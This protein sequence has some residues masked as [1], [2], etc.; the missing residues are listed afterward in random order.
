MQLRKF[1]FYHFHKNVSDIDIINIWL[2]L[3]KDSEQMIDHIRVKIP[4]A[5]IS[6]EKALEDI[7]TPGFITP[8]STQSTF[9]KIILYAQSD[10]LA[11]SAYKVG[12]SLNEHQLLYLIPKK[13]K[14]KAEVFFNSRKVPH[15][16]YSYSLLRSFRPDVFVMLNDWSKEAQ[17]IIAHCHLL[18]IPVICLQESVIDFGDKY[19]RM[20][21]ADE[22]FVQGSQTV[23][24]LPR[25]SYYITGNPRYENISKRKNE[26]SYVLINCNFTYGIFEDKR[27]AWLDD[28]HDILVTENL[29]YVISQH[30]RDTGNLSKYN[31]TILSSS[32]SIVD[33]LNNTKFLIT[34]FS[35]LIH[36]ALVMG[37]P[38]IYY[39]PH[40]EKMLYDFEFDGKIVQ[41]ARSR[42]ELAN[43]VKTVKDLIVDENYLNQYL[44]KHCICKTSPPSVNIA[45]ILTST[46]FDP[47]KLTA[48]DVV[49]LGLYHP[50]VK[51]I[52]S[53]IR[54]FFT[55]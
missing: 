43:C 55:K 25:S 2:P 21:W 9:R 20:Q 8:I 42:E 14:E 31:K 24:D 44:T 50:M 10:T 53:K 40:G 37:I 17:R 34:R 16:K 51:N 36:E 12:E 1:Y 54:R 49:K 47:V 29:E 52:L 28:I 38:V 32:A 19:K 7:F 39:N 45:F 48:T 11:N 13:S 23:I 15:Q 26:G 41:F 27:E 22:V 18:K 5:E 3:A 46:N 33:Q 4:N 6:V 35:S 30:P